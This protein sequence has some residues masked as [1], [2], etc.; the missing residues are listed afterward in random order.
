MNYTR[1]A[2]DTLSHPSYNFGKFAGNASQGEKR[3]VQL[4]S[5]TLLR[6]SALE[7]V[8]KIS[9]RNPKDFACQQKSISRRLS[10]PMVNLLRQKNL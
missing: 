3:I 9:D 6:G 7:S 5:E 2:I 4:S 1:K 8:L 10:A